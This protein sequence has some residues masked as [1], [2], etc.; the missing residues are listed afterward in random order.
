MD[1]KKSEISTKKKVI[2]TSLLLLCFI[3]IACLFLWS[4]NQEPQKQIAQHEQQKEKIDYLSKVHGLRNW[5]IAVNSKD[6]DFLEG[7]TWDKN[8]IKDVQVNH[9]KVDFQKVG[10][11]QI[12]YTI[13]PIDKK[14]SIIKINKN[15]TVTDKKNLI[16]NNDNKQSKKLAKKKDKDSSAKKEDNKENNKPSSK[17]SNKPSN[18]NSS[19]KPSQ[20][21]KPH[22]SLGTCKSGTERTYGIWCRM[23]ITWLLRK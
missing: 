17:P 18:N 11:Y 16:S 14:A 8:Y 1:N 13:L 19:Q 12:T 10:N 4:N 6:V 3:G 22:T 20:P 2:L 15:V 23:Q 7:V 21:T 5:K 9:Q